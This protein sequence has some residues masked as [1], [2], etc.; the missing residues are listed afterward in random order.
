[1]PNEQQVTTSERLWS[2]EVGIAEAHDPVLAVQRQKRQ[3][4]YEFSNGRVFE[5]GDG[6]YA[7]PQ[8]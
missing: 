8:T 3:P 2:E 5:E 4:A 1:M 6:P 7:D